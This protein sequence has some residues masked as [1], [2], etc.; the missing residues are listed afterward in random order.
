MKEIANFL[1]LG[2]YA[3]TARGFLKSADFVAKYG[4]AGLSA[5][6]LREDFAEASTLPFLALNPHPFQAIEI[7]RTLT[8][9]LPASRE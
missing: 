2:K 3:T 9:T 8:G 5:I 4:V 6:F 7:L 1:P